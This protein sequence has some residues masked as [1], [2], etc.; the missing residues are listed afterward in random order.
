MGG[1]LGIEVSSNSFSF[2][3]EDAEAVRGLSIHQSPSEPAFA[4]EENS[5]DLLESVK[6]DLEDIKA[7]DAN[8]VEEKTNDV[9]KVFEGV[10][11]ESIWSSSHK[12]KSEPKLQELQVRIPKLNLREEHREENNANMKEIP[13]RDHSKAKSHQ[14]S[15]CLKKFSRMRNLTA[16]IETVHNKVKPFQCDQ[17]LKKFSQKHNLRNHIGIVHN[18]EKPHA[19]PQP[20]CAEIF[21]LKT[22]L[23]RHMVKVHNF[24][25]PYHCVEK[26]CDKKCLDHRTLNDHLRSA[27][28]AAKLVCGFQNCAATFNSRGGLFYHEMKYHTDK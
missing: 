17:C 6:E 26:N 21:G 16:H 2:N 7:S 25:K 14:C 8:N 13:V 24:E 12:K 15:Q 10:T 9:V 5:N 20:G 22:S 18:R 19:C 4:P 11:V 3:T 28:G 1:A 27:H 23:R